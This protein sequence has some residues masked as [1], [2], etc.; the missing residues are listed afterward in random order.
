MEYKKNMVCTVTIERCSGNG[1]G[2]S[3]LDGRVVFVQGALPGEECEIKLLKIKKTVLFAKVERILK[4]SPFRTVPDCSHFPVCGGCSF[5]HMTYEEEL[6]IKRQQVED[7]LTRIGGLSCK[8]PPVL[9]AETV[10]R[11][12]NKAQFP[13]S[14]AK[15]GGK[16]GFYRSRS[17]DVISVENCLI[18]SESAN[19]A[20]NTV[21]KWME[22]YQIPG[23]EETTCS[24]LVRHVYVRTNQA[25]ESLICLVVN[26]S[27]VPHKKELVQA[28]RTAC[29]SAVGILLNRNEK[30]SNVILGD[31]YQLLWGQDYLID[32]L[33]GHSFRLSVPSFYQVNHA[34]T[35]RLY[36]IAI[37]YAAFTG[38][39]TVLDLYCG[40]GTISLSMAEA[41]KRVIGVEIIPEAVRDA[42]ENAQR[43]QISNAEFFCADA[44]VAAEKLLK[45]GVTPDVVVVDPPRKGLDQGVIDAILRLNPSRL[46]Y[47]SCDPATLARDLKL[48]SEQGYQLKK[49]TSVD[50]FPRTTHVETCVLLDRND[51]GYQGKQEDES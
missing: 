9:G 45:E 4:P 11:Y 49:I 19:T 3:H 41:V 28:L 35:E 8:V 5:W 25:G 12:R 44:G 26:G 32:E 10:F 43:N 37:S 38:E 1:S 16:I 34:Q 40:V 33:L 50:M 20:A 30:D 21:R 17:H 39:E 31:Q 23:Y 48:F 7:A 24:G 6:E 36:Q 51:T 15:G 29:P 2:I 13:V 18:Q 22:Q 46:V 27:K 47:V 42:N 14:A